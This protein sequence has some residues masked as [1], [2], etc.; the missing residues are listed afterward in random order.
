MSFAGAVVRPSKLAATPASY[1]IEPI[2]QRARQ[3]GKA[4]PLASGGLI[5]P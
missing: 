4:D 1:P 5:A 2:L 3:S